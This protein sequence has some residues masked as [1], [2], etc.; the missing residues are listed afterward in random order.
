MLES[1]PWVR[2]VWHL[3]EVL[4]QSCT[5]LRAGCL[6]AAECSKRFRTNERVFPRCFRLFFGSCSVRTTGSR[7]AA[8]TSST[9]SVAWADAW[10]VSAPSR[11]T[12]PAMVSFAR[13]SMPQCHFFHRLRECS[14]AILRAELDL[15]GLS[16]TRNAFATSRVGCLCRRRAG[17]D[18]RDC[19]RVHGSTAIE[20]TAESQAEP[21]LDLV[22]VCDRTSSEFMGSRPIG[23]ESCVSLPG[24]GWESVP[25]RCSRSMWGT[26][27][28]R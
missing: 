6:G 7:D 4:A 21:G 28:R 26:S 13:L 11:I 10:Q 3:T 22:R 8:A 1:M 15:S 23:V 18:V 17:F 16:N 5:A 2:S 20:Q 14:R 12:P 27:I 25:C 19:C 9:A 24:W